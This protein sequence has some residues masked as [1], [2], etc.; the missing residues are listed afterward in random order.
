LRLAAALAR[1]AWSLIATAGSP[2]RAGRQPVDARCRRTQ[3]RRAEGVV[4]ESGLD[5][6]DSERVGF[7]PTNL[8]DAPD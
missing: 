1:L 8:V 2:T 4:A 3:P 5:D 6:A 7:V